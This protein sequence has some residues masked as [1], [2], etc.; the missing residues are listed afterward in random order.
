M[1]RRC[2]ARGPRRDGFALIA[3]LALLVVLGTTGAA[4]LRMTSLQQAGTSRALLAERG[5]QAARSG[6]EWAR[7]SARTRGACPAA[8]STVL[9]SEGALAGFQVVVTCE[10]T[11][12]SEGTDERVTVQLEARATSGTVGSREFVYREAT[13]TMTF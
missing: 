2:G 1:G 7:R 6:I 11:H 9:L 12:H 13:E 4:M 5:A 8:V 3:A 10:A